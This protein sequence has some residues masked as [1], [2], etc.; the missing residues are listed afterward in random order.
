MSS[1][2][3]PRR[4]AER[5]TVVCFVRHG[6]TPTTGRLL[7]GR[8]RG[9]HLSEAGLEEAKA[10]AG[11][12]AGLAVAAVYS[13]PLERTRETAA[14]IADAVGTTVVV[15]RGLVECDFGGWTGSELAKLRKL[16]E[17][18]T[19]QHFPSGWRF[20]AGESFSELQARML[21]TVE[22]YRRE[23]A[24]QVVVAVSHA[25]C[26]KAALAAYLG[27]PLDLFQ[28]IDVGPC[29]TSAVALGE[30]GPRVLALNSYGPLRGLPEA[31]G[32]HAG[33]RRPRE[34]AAL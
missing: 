27:T 5:P 12:F 1:V 30:G 16:P 19:V 25:D 11:R 14:P 7:P 18:R 10:A 23:H 22:R 2:Q 8:A 33:G 17:W 29:S 20:P 6:T 13:S 26:V 4:T 3:R 34:G 21:A 31:G 9:L 28:R 24:G 32:S 15:D